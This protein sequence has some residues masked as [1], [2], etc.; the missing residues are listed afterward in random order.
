MAFGGSFVGASHTQ[1]IFEIAGLALFLL[2]F[3]QLLRQSAMPSFKSVAYLIV[4]A[5]VAAGGA[6]LMLR[7]ELRLTL[8]ILLIAVMP[9]NLRLF[10]RSHPSNCACIENR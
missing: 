1:W 10:R 6:W 7:W 9:G 5:T 4:T 3:W 8:W 2:A